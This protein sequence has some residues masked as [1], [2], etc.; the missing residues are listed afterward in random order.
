MHKGWGESLFV[1]GAEIVQTVYDDKNR[2]AVL[3]VKYTWYR[4]TE[5]VVYETV[6]LQHWEYV[7]AKWKMMAEEYQSGKSF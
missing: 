6:T 1:S 5:M 3:T 4:K 7:N 2:K